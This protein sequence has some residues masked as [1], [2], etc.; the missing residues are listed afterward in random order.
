MQNT[1]IFVL[2]SFT[3]KLSLLSFFFTMF[4]VPTGQQLVIYQ[5]DVNENHIIAHE[6]KHLS[7]SGWYHFVQKVSMLLIKGILNSESDDEVMC[8]MIT[9]G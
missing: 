1:P 9:M 4:R 6:T 7:I 5:Q 3:S 8:K 2:L